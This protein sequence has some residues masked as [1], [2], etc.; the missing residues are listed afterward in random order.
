MHLVYHQLE[1]VD[2]SIE[3]RFRDVQ[4]VNIFDFPFYLCF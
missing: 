1:T 4:T 3:N 2:N